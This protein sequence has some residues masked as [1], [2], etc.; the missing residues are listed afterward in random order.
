M[1]HI[2]GVIDGSIPFA[3]GQAHKITG[4]IAFDLFKIREQAT[5]RATTIEQRDIVTT[6]QEFTHHVRPDKARATQDKNIEWLANSIAR[7][8]VFTLNTDPCRGRQAACRYGTTEQA[9]LDKFT[10]VVRHC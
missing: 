10:S 2:T 9:R 7:L 8:A 4:T 3:P 5:V 6:A 1:R